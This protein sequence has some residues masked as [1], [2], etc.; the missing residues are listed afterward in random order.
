M[1]AEL[2]LIIL[3]ASILS[4]NLHHS[5]AFVSEALIIQVVRK[6]LV[7]RVSLTPNA[8]A[9]QRFDYAPTSVKHAFW[10]RMHELVAEFRFLRLLRSL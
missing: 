4:Y 9:D 10:L 3:H 5:H 1:P 2:K 7:M 8:R 6:L